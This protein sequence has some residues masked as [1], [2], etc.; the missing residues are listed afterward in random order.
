METIKLK[1]C[2]FCGGEAHVLK[3]VPYIIGIG[4]IM[5]TTIECGNCYAT[6]G[7]KYDSF[8]LAAEKWNERVNIGGL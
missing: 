8:N 4:R 7:T 3:V 1:P 5:D 2:P 6:I